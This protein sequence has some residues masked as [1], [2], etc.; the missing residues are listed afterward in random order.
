MDLVFLD[1]QM[2]GKDGFGV[3]E[4]IGLANMPMTVFVTAHNDYAVEAF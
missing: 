4:E 1:I 3:I 2:P